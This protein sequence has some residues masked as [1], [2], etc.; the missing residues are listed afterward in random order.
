MLKFKKR[1]AVH[2]VQQT[3][4]EIILGALV[5]FAMFSYVNRARDAG[6]SQKEWLSKDFALFLDAVP[7]G[8]GNYY[9]SYRYFPDTKD[10]GMPK[11]YSYEFDVSA[12]QIKISSATQAYASDR[13]TGTF[14]GQSKG[15]MAVNLVKADGQELGLPSEIE[16]R[17]LQIACAAEKQQEPNLF[18]VP[19]DESSK[20]IADPLV[21]RNGNLFSPSTK[22]IADML[23]MTAE[24]RINLAKSKSMPAIEFVAV[25]GSYAKAYFAS[26]DSRSRQLA[27]RMLNG[28]TEQL[29]T[30]KQVNPD[31][32]IAELVGPIKGAALVP[33]NKE[34]IS[35]KGEF[36]IVLLNYNNPNVVIE[37]GSELAKQNKELVA[38]IYSGVNVQV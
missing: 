10:A 28:I 19:A 23:K 12:N 33:L 32:T 22:I 2:P 3:M 18:L 11:F 8:Q 31:N 35:E 25:Q 17:K 24:D 6:L 29:T 21:V 36:G 30:I 26:G 9:L 14:E 7:A 38:G 4:I 13:T 37:L 1:G 16:P 15:W 20:Q 27:C 5:V 34:F